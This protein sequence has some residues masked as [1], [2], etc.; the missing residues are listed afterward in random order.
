M[1]TYL[2]NSIQKLDTCLKL[3][4]DTTCYKN[5]AEQYECQMSADVFFLICNKSFQL[6]LFTLFLEL[7]FLFHRSF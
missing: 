7:I 5:V 1:K 2:T 3:A 4:D 6:M